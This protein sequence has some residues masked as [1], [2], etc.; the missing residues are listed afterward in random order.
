MLYASD[1]KLIYRPKVLDNQGIK[2]IK[3]KP[4]LNRKSNFADLTGRPVNQFI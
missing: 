3:G 1:Y 2:L 4:I